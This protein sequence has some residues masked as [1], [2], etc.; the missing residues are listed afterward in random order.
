MARA[1]TQVL[2]VARRR[3]LIGSQYL[4]GFVF[5]VVGAAPIRGRRLR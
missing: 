2:I 5:L 3:A 1:G 4:A